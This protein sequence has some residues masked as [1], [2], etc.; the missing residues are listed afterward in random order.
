[1]PR[2][3]RQALGPA[4]SADG[5]YVVAFESFADNL[6]PDDSNAT[7]DVFVHDWN[8]NQHTHVSVSSTGKQANGQSG[9]PALSA[10][11]R[12]VA[13]SSLASNLVANDKNNARDIFV[14]DLQTGATSRVS[15]DSTGKPG[16]GDAYGPAISADGNLVAFCSL[17]SNLVPGDSNGMADIFVHDRQTGQTTRVSL[18][19]GGVQGTIAAYHAALMMCSGTTAAPARRI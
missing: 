19:T 11:G 14:H 2:R 15:V 8:K 4:L 16:N 9:D 13:F 17:A 10:N 18:S 3:G 6:V 5:G 7:A 1:M 12:S